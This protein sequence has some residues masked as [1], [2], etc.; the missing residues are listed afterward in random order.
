MFKKRIGSIITLALLLVIGT[1]AILNLQHIRDTV[2]YYQY[3]PDSAVAQLALDSGMNDRGKF[4]FYASH[5]ALSDADS[6]NKECGPPEEFAAIL[7]CYTGL[8]IYIY[9]ITD[10]R[11]AGIRP[12]TAAHE[13]LHAAYER[14]GE[15]ERQRVDTLLEAEYNKLKDNEELASKMSFYERAQP[16][17]RLNEL[18]SIIGTEIGQLSSELERYY[19]QYFSDRTKVVAQHDQY[20]LVFDTLKTRA[21]ILNGQIDRLKGQIEQSR[22]AYETRARALDAKVAV[23]NDRADRGDFEDQAGFTRERQVLLAET[24]Q[25]DRL[26]IE[27]NANVDEYNKLVA[28]LSSIA[29][30]TNTLNRSMS[31]VEPTPSL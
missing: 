4:L 30:E 6:F 11:L 24:A 14:L 26:R 29:T 22:T 19:S 10:P 31:S 13:M 12:T 8:N 2:Q 18:H 23:F 20:R 5:P 9:D 1:A 17:Q 28:E 3:T 7:G 15:K 16:G 21:N 25:L 27:I